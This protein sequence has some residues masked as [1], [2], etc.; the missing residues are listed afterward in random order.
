MEAG[1]ARELQDV[2]SATIDPGSCAKDDWPS[3]LT[4]LDGYGLLSQAFS[5][6]PSVFRFCLYLFSA[7][8]R[9]FDCGVFFSR[10]FSE[11]DL[12]FGLSNSTLLY[13]D[14]QVAPK[15]L[16]RWIEPVSLL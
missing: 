16:Q 6:L 13:I 15:Q 1:D 10:L 7:G 4:V 14:C 2:V 3:R 12:Y 8:E 9:Y 11:E 5:T